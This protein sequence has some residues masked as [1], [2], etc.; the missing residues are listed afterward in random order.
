[1][2]FPVKSV[3]KS[4]ARWV[5]FSAGLFIVTGM[6]FFLGI[7]FIE[8]STL[9]EFSD[10]SLEEMD[11]LIE[12]VLGGPPLITTLLIFLNNTMTAL[13]MLFLGVFLG[14]SP[15]FTITFNGAMLGGV[16][17]SIASEGG[18]LEAFWALIAG[19]LPHGIPELF[20][21]FISS[22]LGLKLGYHCIIRPLA[23]KN[24]WQSLLFIW[25]EIISVLPLMVALLF[26]AAFIEIFVTMNLLELL[27]AG[28]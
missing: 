10:S 2:F 17:G 26:I 22:A 28:N 16:L 12:L 1:M 19:I 8:A 3:I 7:S 6:F 27:N 14:I 13:Q 18:F 23:G 15:L 5:L 20:A 25:K 24:R 9:V 21:I 11:G 4:N